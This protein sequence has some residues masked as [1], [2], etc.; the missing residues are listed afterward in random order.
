MMHGSP[1]P[2]KAFIRLGLT[3]VALYTCGPM[4]VW[5]SELDISVPRPQEF[6]LFYFFSDAWGQ[7]P[8]PH[9]CWARLPL[10][11]LPNPLV[12]LYCYVTGTHPF[13]SG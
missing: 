5:R 3:Y 13:C 8:R 7:T 9:T 1:L 10:S 2:A 4:L 6:L 12:G 11:Y